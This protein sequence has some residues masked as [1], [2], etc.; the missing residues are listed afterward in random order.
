MVYLMNSYNTLP[1][2]LELPFD[3]PFDHCPMC[4]PSGDSQKDRF[5]SLCS[6]HW[7]EHDASF[8]RS[9]F[10][11]D[12]VQALEQGLKNAQAYLKLTSRPRL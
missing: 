3:G 2:Q 9:R 12:M 7:R 4:N 6:R 11:A 1:C 8:D 5:R 10:R